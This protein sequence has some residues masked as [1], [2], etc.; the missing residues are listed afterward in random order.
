VTT[1][2]TTAGTA[3]E[4]PRS[5]GAVRALLQALYAVVLIALASAAL[6]GWRDH[7]RAETRELQLESEIAATEARIAALKLRIERLQHDPA[8][9]DRV[10]REELGLVRP[11]EVVIVL[12]ER[13]PNRP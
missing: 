6:K 10:A 1:A 8:T 11:E 13:A 4:R 5:P 9:L 3:G 2:A 12:P 7:Q